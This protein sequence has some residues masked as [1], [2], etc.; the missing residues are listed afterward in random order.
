VLWIR[1][2]IWIWIRIP[3]DLAV[4]DPDPDAEEWNFNKYTWLPAFQKDFCTFV[5]MFFDLLPGTYFEY[6][7]FVKIQLFVTL[8][9]TR[10][11]IRMHPHW[12]DSLDSDP[13]SDP[14]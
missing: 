2:W 3:I 11:R 9:L 6:I 13:D 10:I 14:H 5:G 8:S 7:F 12:F 1:I 4:L